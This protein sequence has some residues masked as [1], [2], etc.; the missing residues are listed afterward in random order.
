MNYLK[1][2]KNHPLEKS[3][4]PNFR[5]LKTLKCYARLKCRQ[6]TVSIN[7][8]LVVNNNLENFILP[9]ALNNLKNKIIEDSQKEIIDIINLVLEKVFLQK[10]NKKNSLIENQLKKIIKNKN[11]IFRLEIAAAES[12]NLSPTIKAN[13]DIQINNQLKKGL[14]VLFLE[15]RRIEINLQNQIQHIQTL[16][17][18]SE[19]FSLELKKSIKKLL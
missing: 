12:K 19:I 9:L 7:S 17:N 14:A 6:Q 10:S 15:D 11:K 5:L 13:L 18:D 8:S 16:I 1:V 4:D 3:L 2:F